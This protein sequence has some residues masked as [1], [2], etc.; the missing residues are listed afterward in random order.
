MELVERIKRY[1]VV[2]NSQIDDDTI[3]LFIEDAK[4]AILN[5]CNLTVFPPELT[6]V[7]CRFVLDMIKDSLA[8][9]G[10]AKAGAV[11]SVSEGDSTIRY[12][13]GSS[14]ADAAMRL[15]NSVT[16]MAQLKEFRRGAV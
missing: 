4:M 8:D 10:Q 7:L 15:Q 2:K 14:A 12:G 16:M 11:S 9:S 6:N 13:H 5:F 3:E 1:P